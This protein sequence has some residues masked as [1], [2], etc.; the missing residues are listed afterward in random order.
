[1][2]EDI[3]TGEDKRSKHKSILE[4]LEFQSGYLNEMSQLL[5]KPS[6]DSMH[7]IRQWLKDRNEDIAHYKE[8]IHFESKYRWD[9]QINANYG[10]FE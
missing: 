7:F 4:A 10:S 3:A 9:R 2:K 6:V 1:M 5:G 8:K